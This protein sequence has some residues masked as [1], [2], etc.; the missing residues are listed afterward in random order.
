MLRGV[1]HAHIV[2]FL[3]PDDKLKNDI[4]RIDQMIWAE[5]P[6]DFNSKECKEYLE[7]YRSS[8]DH[9]PHRWKQPDTNDSND[10]EDK[11]DYQKNS[12]PKIV[13]TSSII[14]IIII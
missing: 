14:I 11:L 13:P 10:S 2:A 3:H 12:E 9:R 8:D 4:N 6:I 1:P 5:I 7:Q